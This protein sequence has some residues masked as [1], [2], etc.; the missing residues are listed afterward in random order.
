M[1]FARPLRSLL[2]LLGTQVV[3]FE[4][5][6]LESGRLT[7]GHPFLAAGPFEI[8]R[9]D[10]ALLESTLESAFVVADRGRRRA[11]ILAEIERALSAHGSELAELDLLEE[12]TD[13]VEWP[14]LLEGSFDEKFLEL[15]E[16]V[17]T[18]AMMEHQRY[19]PVRDS[20]RRL[21]NRFL[22]VAN[23]P[24]EYCEAIREGN[25]R[26]LRARLVDATFFWE[27]DRA[28]PLEEFAGGLSG[29][30]Y[31][32]GL[33][34]VA[35]KVER[36]KALAAWA[37][38]AAGKPEYQAAAVEA[39][40]LSKADLLTEMV[41]EFTSLQGVMG[42]AYALAQG[43]P[44][45]VA[46]AIEEHYMP[47]TLSSDLPTTETGKLA[48]LA[49]KADTLAGAFVMGLL[50]SGSQDP[51]GL[52]RAAVGIVRIIVEGGVAVPLEGLLKEA[53]SLASKSAAAGPKA[54]FEALVAFVRD[55]LYSF[56]LERGYRYDVLNA[57]LAPG[58]DDLP[59]FARRLDVVA[60]LSREPL[61]AD[62][63][64]SVERTFNITKSF[65]AEVEPEVSL[66]EAG[67]EKEL[68]EL[69]YSKAPWIGQL[70]SEGDYDAA[71]RAYVE[72]FAAPLHA[73][74]DA[75]YVNVEDV[76]VRQNRLALIR[77]INRLYSTRIADLSEIVTE[78]A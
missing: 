5:D 77:A 15:P 23:R 66:L 61:W 29:V 30:V 73:F 22:T 76:R 7:W 17:V 75:V 72:T 37:A 24:A 18:A 31:L 64:T 40:A 50:P 33:G 74:F 44:P 63:V 59:D 38:D 45:E 57:V 27:V 10:L 19:F 51:Y 28:K 11:H 13:L 62:L 46:R 9:A 3:P 65:T 14:E 1:R 25:E 35:D 47:R 43:K 70:V 53:W 41:F 39:A 55:R 36:M 48:A 21:V 8:E 78:G 54:G 49:D 34:T 16:E 26:V 32:A 12:V 20:R 68:F 52:R 67:E 42:R 6:G 4:V 69:D 56:Y 60:A 2:A 71:S 58:F